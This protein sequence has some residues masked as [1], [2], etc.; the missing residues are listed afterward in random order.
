MSV[1]N[2]VKGIA[3]LIEPTKVKGST[4]SLVNLV[5]NEG[6][7]EH[8]AHYVPIAGVGVTM[9]VAAVYVVRPRLGGT[10]IR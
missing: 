5:N 2:K 10:R 4:G 6:L 8:L 7:V 9:L 3:D 1:P